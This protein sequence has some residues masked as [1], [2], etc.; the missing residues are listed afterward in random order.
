MLAAGIVILIAGA[1]LVARADTVGRFLAGPLH[2]APAALAGLFLLRKRPK[3]ARETTRYLGDWYRVIEYGAAIIAL[4]FERYDAVETPRDANAAL[5]R[6][7]AASGVSGMS[8]ATNRC[9]KL[10]SVTSITS[11]RSSPA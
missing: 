9:L 2:S 3:T 1:G 7:T 5:I 10:L 8:T 6:C 4:R 11:T